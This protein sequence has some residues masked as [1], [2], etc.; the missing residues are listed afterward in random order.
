MSIAKAKKAT[1]SGDFIEFAQQAY[2]NGSSP[3]ILDVLLHPPSVRWG[4]DTKVARYGLISWCKD[5]VADE[6]L[7]QIKNAPENNEFRAGMVGCL[8]L[9]GLG[10]VNKAISASENLFEAVEKTNEYPFYA[11][12]MLRELTRARIEWSGAQNDA[13]FVR[14]DKEYLNSTICSVIDDLKV[15]GRLYKDGDVVEYCKGM[16]KVGNRD[17]ANQL[18][19]DYLAALTDFDDVVSLVGEL[20]S[21][22]PGMAAEMR[23]NMVLP[24]PFVSK[25]TFAECI[26]T[27]NA[28]VSPDR[29]EDI[30]YLEEY[31]QNA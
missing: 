31:V 28:L 9:F 1:N 18:I 20:S 22:A 14:I 23:T 8:Y 13:Y 10:N 11:S 19:V 21:T 27:A 7:F 30:K 17:G 15:M 26:K 3:A 16:A 6:L 5:T 2:V 25:N 4:T 29:S 12:L 24:V